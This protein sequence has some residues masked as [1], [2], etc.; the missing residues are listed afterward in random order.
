MDKIVPIYIS[1]P[2]VAVVLVLAVKV[3]WGWG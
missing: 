3:L 1:G 2:V